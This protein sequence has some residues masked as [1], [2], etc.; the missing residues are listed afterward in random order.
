MGQMIDIEIVGDYFHLAFLNRNQASAKRK[1]NN[2]EDKKKSQKA[3][4]TREKRLEW[5]EVI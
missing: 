5:R 1:H 2:F 3:R 4:K